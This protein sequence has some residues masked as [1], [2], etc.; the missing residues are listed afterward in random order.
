MDHKNEDISESVNPIDSGTIFQPIRGQHL[1][2]NVLFMSV[3]AFQ[4]NLYV[5]TDFL[6]TPKNRDFH[7]ISNF[8]ENAQEAS[9]KFLECIQNS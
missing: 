5:W 4:K 8:L 9:S 6:M 7:E 1:S 3:Y 2:R